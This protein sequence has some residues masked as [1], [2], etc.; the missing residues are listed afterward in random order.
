MILMQAFCTTLSDFHIEKTEWLLLVSTKHKL[1]KN[2]FCSTQM[3]MEIEKKTF[4]SE[5]CQLCKSHSLNGD[6]PSKK[7]IL[8]PIA[9]GTKKNTPKK[10]LCQK[11]FFIFLENG[12]LKSL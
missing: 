4:T 11:A 9:I 6:L 12:I 8:I 5:L 10:H 7:I 3:Q 2:T 1:V